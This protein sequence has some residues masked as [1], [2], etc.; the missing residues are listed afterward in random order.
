MRGTCVTL[1]YLN[2]PEATR[3]AFDPEG[4]KERPPLTASGK[5]LRRLLR[6]KEWAGAKN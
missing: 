1:D 5:A 4:R 3:A 6:D 2:K